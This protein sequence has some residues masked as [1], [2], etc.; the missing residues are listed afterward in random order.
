MVGDWQV[1]GLVKESVLKPVF[2]TGE[3]GQVLRIMGKLAAADGKA[4]SELVAE[5]IG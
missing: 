3:Q 1:A 2:A 4:L 5:V